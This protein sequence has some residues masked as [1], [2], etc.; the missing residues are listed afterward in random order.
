MKGLSQELELRRDILKST[1]MAKETFRWSPLIRVPCPSWLRS[2]SRSVPH[3]KTMNVNT[4][5]CTC[6]RSNNVDVREENEPSFTRGLYH[7]SHLDGSCSVGLFF[8]LSFLI[9]ST[10]ER[11]GHSHS[12]RTHF[13]VMHGCIFL[14]HTVT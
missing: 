11:I 14:S 6:F 4:H 1:S 13:V 7:L 12:W 3:G 5:I 10:T 2:R 9:C 8:G